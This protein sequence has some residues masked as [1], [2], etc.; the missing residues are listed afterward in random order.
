M[1][2]S[3][4]HAAMKQLTSEL[5]GERQEAI[6]AIEAAPENY[7]PPVF[8]LLSAVLFHMGRKDDAP[9]WFYAG[10]LRA[11][12]DANR[13]ADYTAGG[14]VDVLNESYG[15]PIN[16]HMF[17]DLP[18]LKKLIP[19]VVEWDRKTP[20]CYDH[21]WINPHGIEAISASILLKGSGE[22]AKSV[23]E[24]HWEAIAEKLEPII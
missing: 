18:G 2:S 3:L 6:D 5:A 11:R 12:F 21:H 1:T 13:C 14:A 15:L 4:S 23:P 16:Q 17:R 7:I 10:Q 9:F 19:R 8:Y 22:A 20:H 24:E